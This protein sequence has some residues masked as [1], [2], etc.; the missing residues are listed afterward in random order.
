MFIDTVAGILGDYAVTSSIEM[1][2]TSKY[3]RHPTE[4]AQLRGARLVVAQETE[5][6]RSWDEAKI[7]NLTGGDRLNARFMRGDFF[8]FQPT[9]KLLISGNTKPSLRHVDNAI[10]RRF[11]LIP[12]TVT[13][14]DHEQDPDLADKLRAEW[15]AILGW[16]LAGC[17][18][19][20]DGGLKV[21]PIVRDATDD[22][23]AEEDSVAQWIA[24]HIVRD[25]MA[26]TATT[27]LFLSWAAWCKTRNLTPGTEKSFVAE[28]ADKDYAQKRTGKA[29]G[30]KGIALKRWSADDGL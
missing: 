9:H 29:R 30:F 15:P 5:K 10:R 3:D 1:F 27:E 8:N 7:K 6:G 28:L 19:W 16:M 18:D 4:I 11:L 20:R 17:L 12:F 21:P 13:I 23:L 24:D 22:Y 2:L 14:P 25:P 26:F